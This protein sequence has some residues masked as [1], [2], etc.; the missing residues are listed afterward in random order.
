MWNVGPPKPFC[1]PPPPYGITKQ[2]RLPARKAQRSACEARAGGLRQ[3]RGVTWAESRHSTAAVEG[4]DDCGSAG[5]D[6]D[7]KQPR[8]AQVRI[9]PG[10]GTSKSVIDASNGL[11]LP[12]Q[13]HNASS[14]EGDADFIFNL[15]VLG[16]AKVG[17]TT[18]LRSMLAGAP[19]PGQIVRVTDRL[20]YASICLQAGSSPPAQWA[21]RSSIQTA[22][23]RRD[24]VDI[25]QPLPDAHTIKL[26]VWELSLAGEQDEEAAQES[27]RELL[28][29][30]DG[31]FLLYKITL[32][33]TLGSC[34]GYWHKVLRNAVGQPRASD[35][36]R[37]EDKTTPPE[38]F[39]RFFGLA[40]SEEQYEQKRGSVRRDRLA[41]DS[42]HTASPA[43]HARHAWAQLDGRTQEPVY[44]TSTRG[45]FRDARIGDGIPTPPVTSAARAAAPRAGEC[46]SWQGKK[47]KDGFKEVAVVGAGAAQDADD[48]GGPEP[49]E[50]SHARPTA[51]EPLLLM[52]ATHADRSG[53]AG[54]VPD[55]NG[56]LHM[57]RAVPLDEG[58]SVARQLS[59]AFIEIDSTDQDIA[60]ATLDILVSE[61]YWRAILRES[62]AAGCRALLVLPSPLHG[63]ELS[64]CARNRLLLLLVRC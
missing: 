9:R 4:V 36:Q 64:A 8:L 33:S 12:P 58:K 19:V 16:D 50:G 53:I 40:P 62:R 41:L 6:E 49:E 10:A 7:G 60:Y 51:R 43:L 5:G 34:E 52:V 54:S 39:E 37:S 23:A 44:A 20:H 13:P 14:Q 18:F 2:S 27:F 32:R 31:V 59:S 1:H 17:K 30:A 55:R 48:R 47:G 45:E 25:R 57:R 38:P 3:Q 35:T 26:R 21:Q 29:R 63:A 22:R 61:L 46:G 24:G 28:G 11:Q 56:S 15:V 42:S